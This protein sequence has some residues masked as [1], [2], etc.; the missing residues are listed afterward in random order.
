MKSKQTWSAMRGTILTMCALTLSASLAFA[1]SNK[2]SKDQTGKTSGQVDVIVQFKQAPTAYHHEK[3]LSRGGKIKRELGRFKGGAY[4]MPASAL[5]DLANDPD[6]VYITPDRPLSGAS[7]SS[8]AW[9]LDY[10]S[11]TINTSAATAVGLDGTGIGV[12]IIDSG[13]ANV[14]D[15]TRSN[16]VFSQDFTGDKVN[17]AADQYGHG[18]HVAGIIAGNGNASTG[19]ND[20]YTFKGIAPNVSIVNLRVLDANGN[21]TVSN[22]IAAIQQAIALKST[23]DIK[24][25]NLSLGGPVWESYTVDPLCQ[26]VEQAWQSGITV[27]VA[28][29]NY[30]RDNDAGNNGY[31]TITSPGNDPYVITVGAMNTMG[32]PDRTDDVIA[33]YSSKGPSLTDNVIKPDLVAPGNLIVSLYTPADTLNQ[34]NA[35]NEAPTSL[36]QTNGTSA[37][38]GTYFILSGTSMATPMVSGATAL[39]LQQNPAMTPDQVKARLMLTAFKDLQQYATITDPTTGQTFNEQA[40]IFT[41]GAGYLDIQA[42][43]ANTDLAPPTLGSALSPFVGIDA[44][45]DAVLVVDGPSG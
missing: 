4:T 20:F 31:G 22:V 11:E 1:G 34:E 15:L 13:V 5:E 27:V 14:P 35:G 36:Y 23:Y 17:G 45:G 42:A 12:A 43:L 33:S 44:N 37:S 18:T 40:D 41:V 26:A 21:G 16:V 19:P 3:V 6:V 24:V 9:T 29:G 7:T 2:I 38:S 32:T 30:G 39:L 10:H 28:A 8:S 25:I